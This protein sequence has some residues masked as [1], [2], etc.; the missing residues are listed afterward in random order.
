MLRSSTQLGVARVLSGALALLLLVGS[1][2]ASSQF[3]QATQTPRSSRIARAAQ[4]RPAWTVS[5]GAGPGAVVTLLGSTMGPSSSSLGGLPARDTVMTS[6][7][8]FFSVHVP[9][10]GA[11]EVF[12]LQVPAGAP[13]QR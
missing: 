5:T 11:T 1:A 13:T 8:F 10:T 7:P 6:P 4:A 2:F 12:M 3:S 9:Q